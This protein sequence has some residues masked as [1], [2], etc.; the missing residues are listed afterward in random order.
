LPLQVD[1]TFLSSIFSIRKAIESEFT[2]DLEPE[3]VVL[4]SSN[5]QE[6]EQTG[7]RTMI[8][9]VLLER[10]ELTQ[11]TNK[12]MQSKPDKGEILPL[13]KKL[14]PFLDSLERILYLGRSYPQTEE[15]ANWLTSVEGLYFRISNTLEQFGLKAIDAVGKPVDLNCQEVVEYI[16]SRDHGHNHVI[17]E[18]LKGYYYHGKLLRDAQ[19]VVANNPERS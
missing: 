14:I 11:L 10:E 9:Q 6:E 1:T 5:E 16:P 13:M 8:T 7:L 3:R 15:I 4:P 19:V 17:K 12:L 2:L 18:R